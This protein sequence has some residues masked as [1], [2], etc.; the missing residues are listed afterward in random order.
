MASSKSRKQQLRKHYRERRKALSAQF[1]AHAAAGLLDQ[2]IRLK[3]LC[4]ITHIGAFIANDG[5]VSPHLLI[6]HCWSNDIGVSLPILDPEHPG[7]LMFVEYLA[8]SDMQVN[9]YGIPEPVLSH[10]NLTPLS[11][12]GHLLMPLVAFDQFGHRLGMGGGYYDRTL[13]HKSEDHPMLIGVAHEE[14]YCDSLPVED[15][16]IPLK[17]ILTPQRHI[18][19][20]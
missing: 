6:E 2:F 11:N 16:D 5:E 7:H 18:T 20:N 1:Q 12:I 13:A 10:T 9:Q 17:Q 4:D 3:T 19:F 14:Q 15:W 8:D